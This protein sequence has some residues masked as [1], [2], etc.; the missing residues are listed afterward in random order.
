MPRTAHVLGAVLPVEAQADRL[1]LKST[2]VSHVFFPRS[3]E[4]PR[5]L[6]R[7][8]H[9]LVLREGDWR[10]REKEDPAAERLHSHDADVYC[11]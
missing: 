2:W 4:K 11:V 9:E 1:R 10:N 8:E 5:V 3:R 6:R 7:S